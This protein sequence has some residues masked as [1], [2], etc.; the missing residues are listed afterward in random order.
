MFAALVSRSIFGRGS[1]R[2]LRCCLRL[3]SLLLLQ[4]PVA[5]ELFLLLLLP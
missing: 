4:D 1:I 5:D 3:L 2:L